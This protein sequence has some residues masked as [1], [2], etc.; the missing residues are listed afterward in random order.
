MPPRL[1]RI[2]ILKAEKRA[3]SHRISARLAETLHKMRCAA[4]AARYNHRYAHGRTYLPG[5]VQLQTAPAA[6]LRNAG[7]QQ[8]AGAQRFGLPRPVD[9]VQGVRLLPAPAVYPPLPVGIT[10]IVDAHHHTLRAKATRCLADERRLRQRCTVDSHLVGAVLQQQPE[11]VDAA[12]AAAN[13]QGQKYLAGYLLQ[14]SQRQ[15]TTAFSFGGRQV[16]ENQLVNS[17]GFVDFGL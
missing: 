8:L 3:G 4:A 2:L 10:A 16:N 7:E 13:G 1:H 17:L 11:I 12:H 6:I 5:N 15:L 14:Q 9:R